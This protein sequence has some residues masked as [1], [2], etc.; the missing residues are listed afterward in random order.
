VDYLTVIGE[1]TAPGP[2]IPFEPEDIAVFRAMQ[3]GL[4]D[5]YGTAAERC[6][7]ELVRISAL[8]RGHALG[9]SDPWVAAFLDDFAMTGGS[10]HPNAA[11]MAATAEHL[12]KVIRDTQP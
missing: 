10:F 5:A 1:Q 2:G 11:G 6:G 12:E 8:S 4:E 7:T 9:A 3:S